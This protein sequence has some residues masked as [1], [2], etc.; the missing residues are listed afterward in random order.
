MATENVTWET[1]AQHISSC[2]KSVSVVCTGL[3]RKDLATILA[4]VV[5]VFIRLGLVGKP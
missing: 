2:M 3:I 5:D 1:L 4:Y